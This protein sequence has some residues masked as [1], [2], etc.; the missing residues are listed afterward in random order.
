MMIE[1]QLPQ[2]IEPLNFKPLGKPIEENHSSKRLDAYLA[3]HFP[4]LSRAGWKDRVQSGEVLVNDRVV[5]A[6]FSLRPG[7]QIFFFHPAEREPVITERV[8][9]LYDRS[10]IIA[11]NKPS[12]MPIHEGGAFRFQTLEKVIKELYGKDYYPVHRLDKETSGIVLCAAS[13]S[14]RKDL[15]RQLRLQEMRKVYLALTAHEPSQKEFIVSKPIGEAKSSAIRIKKWVCEQY[16]LPSLTVFKH[17]QSHQNYHLLE[18]Q[19]KT[20]RTNQIRIH[21]A[22]A[23]LPLLGDK[24]YH[25]NEEV[26]LEYW[27]EGQTEYV[28]Q[29]TGHHRCA[30]HAH[31]LE[32]FHPALLAKVNVICELALDLKDLLQREAAKKTP[33]MNAPEIVMHA[34]F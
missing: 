19:P 4:F 15:S 6:S 5:K 30:L 31:Q 26:F 2:G 23:G 33:H 28:T 21:A 17:I 10:G 24:L 9:L 3:E 20:G 18:C 22:Y 34:S 1:Q 25:P 13:E 8:Q 32:F 27:D 14:L 11:V 16:G 7:D 29:A 12:G